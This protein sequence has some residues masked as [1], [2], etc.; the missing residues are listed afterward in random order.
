MERCTGSFRSMSWDGARVTEIP[1][2]HHPRTMGK[3]KYGLSRTVEVVFD[4][5]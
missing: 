2:E 1:V 4:L 3:S 5:I